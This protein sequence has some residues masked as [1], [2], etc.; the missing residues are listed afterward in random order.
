MTS[1]NL[2]SSKAQMRKGLLEFCILL[3][4]SQGEIYASEILQKLKD[5]D[6]IVV[7]GTLYPLLSRL[8][9]EKLLS[10]SWVESNSGPPRKYYSL[11]QEGRQ[12]LNQL[13]NTWGKLSQSI[14]SLLI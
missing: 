4:I 3:I 6:L 13:K 2:E 8:K 11:T 14:N 12:A 10:Y 9:S 7:E 1:Q 5:A